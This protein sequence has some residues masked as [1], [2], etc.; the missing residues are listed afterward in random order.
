M[1]GVRV[2][3]AKAAR[4]AQGLGKAKNYLP[5][6][7]ASSEVGRPF[8][9]RHLDPSGSSAK[10]NDAVSGSDQWSPRSAK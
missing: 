2:R 4:A 1:R 8:S 10:R 9:Q 6:S 5:T 7:S 3:H